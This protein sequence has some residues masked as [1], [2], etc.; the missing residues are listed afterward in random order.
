M[1]SQKIDS[2]RNRGALIYVN[3][4]IEFLRKNTIYIPYALLWKIMSNHQCLA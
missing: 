1:G 4:Q 2:K 3:S